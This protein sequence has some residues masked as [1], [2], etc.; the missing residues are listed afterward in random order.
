[1][2]DAHA[3]THLSNCLIPG[4]KIKYAGEKTASYVHQSKLV[5]FRPEAGDKYS[6]SVAQVI[7]FR[8]VDDCRLNSTRVQVTL[9]NLTTNLANAAVDLTP[10]APTLAMFASARL[11]LG[12]QVVEQIEF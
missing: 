2:V 8:L 4:H 10:V 11:L 6:P 1:M 9:N 3:I 12:G 5:K 7:R